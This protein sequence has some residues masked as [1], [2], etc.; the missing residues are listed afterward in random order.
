MIQISCCHLPRNTLQDCLCTTLALDGKKIASW[1]HFT[2][3]AESR[4][5]L[6]HYVKCFLSLA[7]AA[8]RFAMRPHLPLSVLA[9]YTDF[10]RALQPKAEQWELLIDNW[11]LFLM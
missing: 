9:T 8:Q 7:S 3:I 5:F 1:L 4:N 2:Q 6:G 11:K 10:E